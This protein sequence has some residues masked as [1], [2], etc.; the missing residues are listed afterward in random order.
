MSNEIIKE[1]FIKKKYSGILTSF[2]FLFILLMLI[3]AINISGGAFLTQITSFNYWIFALIATGFFVSGALAYFDKENYIFIPLLVALLIVTGFIRTQNIPSLIDTSTGE[4]T[5]GPDLDPFLY[6]RHA[7]EIIS[8][9]FHSWD[10]FR[11]APL[12]IESYA[13]KSTMPWAIVGVYKIINLFG[14]YSITY[15]AIISPVIFFI[16]SSIFFFFFVFVVSSLKFNKKESGVIA[17]IAT[18]FYAFNVQ[19]LH[20]TTAGIPEIESLGM[21]FF[22]LAFL[23]FAL[24]WKNK[25]KHKEILFALL[26]GLSTGIMIWTWGGNKFIFLTFSLVSLIMF[27]LNKEKQK[28]FYIFLS[29]VIPSLIS[30]SIKN[31]GIKS[32]FVGINDSLISLIVLYVL[33]FDLIVFERFGKKILNKIKLP[34][35]VKSILFGFS[36]ILVLGMIISAKKVINKF[37]SIIESFIVPF[38]KERIS[39]TVAENA[40]PYLKEVIGAFGN[41][42]WI[43]LIASIFIFYEAT[44]HFK[45]KEKIILNA[46]YIFCLFGLSFSRISSDSL[47]NGEN[48]ISKFLYIGS[49]LLL[50]FVIFWIFIKAHNKKDEKT[51]EAFE[52]IELT[53]IIIL[54]FGILTIISMRGAVRL[55][56]IVAQGFAIISAF[57]PVI[58]YKK[59]KTKDEFVKVFVIIAFIVSTI[60]ILGLF[61][62]YSYSIKE[63]AKYIIPSSYNNQ[64]QKAMG[65]VRENTPT[66]SI[67]VHWWDYGY[68]VQTMGER[69]TVTD[70]AHG[71]TFWD[72]TTARY[73]M[74]AKKPE[75]A[76]SLLKTYN[77]SYLLID[78]TD[79][80]KYGAF[81]K[82][83]SDEKG[84]D[85]Y[86]WIPIMVSDPSQIQE[87]RNGTIIIY[88]GGTILDKDI[89]YKQN[90]TEIFL[91]SEKAGILGVIVEKTNNGVFKQPIGV[92]G[93]NGKQIQIPIRYIYYNEKL[94]DFKSGIN[95]TLRVIPKLTQNSQG[96]QVDPTGAMIY[97]S[98]K[99]QDT[100]FSKLYL[101]DD[102]LNE[103]SNLKIV[104]VEDDFV[105][106]F[107]KNQGW[108]LGE[109]V[110]F[111]GFRGP[112]KI[113]E[114]T[115]SQNTPIHE[116][117]LKL[118]SSKWKYAELDKFF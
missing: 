31:N 63:N 92:F 26:S 93:Y 107:L 24:A 54:S 110:Y 57:L 17:I 3:K 73:L 4:Y 40:Q 41:L 38:G 112:I 115:P 35:N 67:F 118:S 59:M 53:Y 83:G 78:S 79:L 71:N 104:H 8:G 15:A 39:L 96:V 34:Q 29:W 51:I 61:L 45:T 77:V 82:I 97:L 6:L 100:L 98:E 27:F 62:S 25:S 86:S 114:Y 32:I 105:I 89:L 85:R 109:F 91:P 5:L 47:L 76:Y 33:I 30:Y 72:H 55:F 9:N 20:R 108:G 90:E 12:G 2:G 7:K 84:E 21:V 75:E 42:F 46:S 14:E 95:V 102:P 65:W 64:W 88:Q 1:I 68:W 66:N 44:K 81:S 94:V 18:F 11:Q 49:I 69:P 117:F 13:M 58:L 70:G 48:F 28:N 56:F 52:K 101:M 43:F 10:M 36:T 80:G 113:W 37:V 111:N 50:L 87:T 106:E 19:M 16:I 103:Y 23:F 116:E 22:W 99:T 60:V 74:T